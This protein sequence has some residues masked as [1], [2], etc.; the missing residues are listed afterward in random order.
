MNTSLL[1]AL[2]QLEVG[3][4]PA[5]LR[6]HANMGTTDYLAAKLL[7]LVQSAF[8]EAQRPAGVD[9]P[10]LY[11]AVDL[12]MGILK[13]HIPVSVDVKVEI[14]DLD[15]PDAPGLAARAI[16]HDSATSDRL[17]ASPDYQSHT[18]YDLP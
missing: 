1:T 14:L 2:R 11:I 3:C 9:S 10:T 7:E 15:E 18:H 12:T 17:E 6:M 16:E 5:S 4:S 13:T 8:A